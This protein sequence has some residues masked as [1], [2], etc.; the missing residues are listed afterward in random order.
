M[1]ITVKELKEKMSDPNWREDSILVDVRAPGEHKAERIASSI[2]IPLEKLKDFK[3]EL[4]KYKNVYLHCETGGRSTEAC[5]KL[6]EMNLENFINVEGGITEWKEEHL[7]I[8]KSGGMNIHRQVMLTA[9]ILVLVGVLLSLYRTGFIA[10]SIFVSIGLIF[11]G[12]TNICFMA[13]FLRKMP[14]NR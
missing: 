5:S 2:N 8:L 13:R 7:P 1:E 6:K 4:S 12:V 10:I 9:G 14:W 11:G 3:D